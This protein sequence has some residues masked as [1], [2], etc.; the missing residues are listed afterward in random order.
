M[1]KNSNSKKPKPIEIEKEKPNS[2][3]TKPKKPISEIDEIFA[4]RKRKKPEKVEKSSGDVVIEPKKVKKNKEKSV[5]I[6]KDNVFSEVPRHSRKKTADGFTL[7]TEEELG[8]GKSNAGGT[9]LCP[10]DCDCC[11]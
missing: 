11:F 2:S 3:S 1:P 4:G 9:K 6:R 8:I 5:R 10:F 7:Y